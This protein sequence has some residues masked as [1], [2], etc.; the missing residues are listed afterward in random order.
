MSLKKD[1]FVDLAEKVFEK[2]PDRYMIST[3]QI[4]NILSQASLIY[5]NAKRRKGELTEDELT[6]I[7]ILR[8]NL[9]YASGRDKKVE[10]FIRK[11]KLLDYIKNINKDREE[12]ILYCRYLEALVA[13]HKYKGG[14]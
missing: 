3:N 10:D 1:N 11:A 7:Q 5:E 12:L 8:M 9:V 13:F 4:R 6:N 14:K 2:I